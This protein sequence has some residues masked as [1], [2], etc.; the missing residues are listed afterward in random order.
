M[1]FAWNNR[2]SEEQAL[3]QEN[4]F[5]DQQQETLRALMAV[6][7]VAGRPMVRQAQRRVRQR[8]LQMT[9]R[10]KQLRERFGLAILGISL[11]WLMMTPMIWGSYRQIVDYSQ[12]LG[13][14]HCTD[15]ECQVTYLTCWLLPVT[16]VTL[17]IG[18]LR[19]RTTRS[20]RKMDSFIR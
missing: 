8:S 9:A 10:R 1:N 2:G 17:L 12:S 7:V 4:Q 3:S 20:E 6:S 15:M 13:W 5:Q 16:L 14:R 11:V 18:F 19:S